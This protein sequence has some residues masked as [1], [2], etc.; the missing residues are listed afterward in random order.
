[1]LT[2]NISGEA[3]TVS[4]NI[5]IEAMRTPSG[6]AQLRESR[7]GGPLG[8]R[9]QLL[10]P[11][12]HRVGQPL[13]HPREPGIRGGG[14]Y[15]AGETA[16]RAQRRQFIVRADQCL[17]RAIDEIREVRSA[18]NDALHRLGRERRRCRAPSMNAEVATNFNLMTEACS[19][20]ILCECR[21][22]ETGVLGQEIGNRSRNRRQHGEAPE[23]GKRLEQAQKSEARLGHTAGMPH[24][25][26]LVRCR[27]E[28]LTNCLFGQWFGELRIGKQRGIGLGQGPPAKGPSSS[29][30]QSEISPYQD[31]TMLKSLSS[32]MQALLS[33][34]ALQL[35][36]GATHG[37]SYHPQFRRRS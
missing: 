36:F 17:D 35:I 18:A 20:R 8:Y 26:K 2:G 24:P 34:L 31:S 19:L 15:V 12:A 16:Q 10:E 5:F 29:L 32:I 3:T 28:E 27:C 4:G 14:V 9:E 30:R 37:Q 21:H 11:C 13:V 7:L 23:E 25:A 22:G 1:M 6:A 33:L